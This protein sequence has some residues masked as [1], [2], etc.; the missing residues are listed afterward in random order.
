MDELTFKDG[1]IVKRFS[2]P[3]LRDGSVLGRIWSF[4]DVTQCRVAEKRLSEAEEQFRDLVE[5]T[6]TGILIV[7]DRKLAYVNPR[8]CE[9]LGYALQQ[10]L[11]GSNALSLV[12][13]RE[14]PAV[15]DMNRQLLDGK[16]HRIDHKLTALRKDGGTVAI[17]ICSSRASYRGRPAIIS[18]L[19][20]IS[21]KIRIE[22]DNRRYL[23][24][25][26]AA[27]MSTVEV[28]T[29][30]NEMRDPYTAN[31]ARRVADIAVAIGGEFGFDTGRQ[32]GL[33]VAGHLHDIGKIKVP[34]EILS[35]PGK[36]TSL[37]F[38]LIQEH[39]RAGFAVLKS[40]E[41]PWPVAQVAL[42]HHERVDGNGYPQGLRGEEIMLEARIMAVADVFEAMASHRPYRAAMGIEKA[43]A[44][45]ERGRGTKFDT[46]AAD[47]CL[48][49][50]RE[51]RYQLPV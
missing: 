42:Q 21:E 26:K 7:Q 45:I 11:I 5:Q 1:R 30:I 12:V 50:M 40:V 39:A 9:I 6:S 28:A 25:L 14:H 43:L 8:V 27:F 2:S 10:E 33:H 4:H 29:I 23:E 49:L 20:D 37:E 31:H 13:P 19:Q 46:N 36:L 38:Q 17:G 16:A 24:Q 22:Q 18:M 34:S 15:R 48:S 3:L 51:L 41:F 35:K 47:A 44:E 32:E